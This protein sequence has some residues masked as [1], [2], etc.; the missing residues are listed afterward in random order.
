[1][2]TDRFSA[3]PPNDPLQRFDTAQ[4]LVDHQID[5]AYLIAQWR[6]ALASRGIADRNAFE[7]L[8]HW[9]NALLLA[10]RPFLPEAIVMIAIR[11]P[12]DMLVDWL[13]FGGAL[14]LRFESPSAAA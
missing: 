5:G 8:L 13:A 7:W 10:L 12:R 14:P 6:A 9:D 3:Q 4:M 2:L 11:D 1:M